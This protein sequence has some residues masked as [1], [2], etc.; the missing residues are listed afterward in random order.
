MISKNFYE[1][2]RMGLNCNDHGGVIS[3][4]GVLLV[5]SGSLYIYIYIKF[6]LVREN[7]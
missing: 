5:R 1:D 6:N 2:L 3:S 7:K 4:F